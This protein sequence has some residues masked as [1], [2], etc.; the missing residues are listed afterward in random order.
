MVVVLE[1]GLGGRRRG[2]GLWM[3]MGGLLLGL[4]RL[5]VVVVVR[6]EELEEEEVL[7]EMRKMQRM[8]RISMMR[9]SY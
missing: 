4:G 1:V 5:V 2:L 9:G 6:L 7:V 8:K 3:L